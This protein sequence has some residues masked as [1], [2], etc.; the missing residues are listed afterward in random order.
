MKG[1]LAKW[2]GGRYGGVSRSPF[3]DIRRGS[4]FG[5]AFNGSIPTNWPMLEGGPHLQ[6]RIFH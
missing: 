2:Y 1:L 3:H 6:L 5:A 4:S